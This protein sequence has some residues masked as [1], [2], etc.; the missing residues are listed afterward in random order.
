MN[1]ML[2][3]LY[4]TASTAI[5]SMIYVPWLQLKMNFGHM[6]SAFNEAVL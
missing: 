4:L 1:G 5:S 3:Q 2:T 6:L